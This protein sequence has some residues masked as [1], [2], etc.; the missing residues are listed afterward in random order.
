MLYRYSLLVL[1]F[2]TL[3]SSIS[4]SQLPEKWLGHYVGE[5][6]SVNLKGN[7]TQFHMEL[8]ISERSDST[9]HFTIIYGDVDDS[10]RQERAYQL[11]P[12]SSSRFL[13]DEKNGIVLDMS[14][15]N[16][17]LVSVFEVND[18]LLHVS[19]IKTKKGIRFEL[20]SSVLTKITGGNT[21]DQGEEIPEVQSYS[22]VSFQYA[23]L[24]LSKKRK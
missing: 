19:Y 16:D 6:S 11:I 22:T 4:F 17:R 14:L 3:G 9:Y 8:I 18:N 7:T 12:T 5:L 13:L 2:F 1:L 24:K 10:L 21:T 15:G 23:N 20:T